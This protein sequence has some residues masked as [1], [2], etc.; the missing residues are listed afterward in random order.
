MTSSR[1]Q[2]HGCGDRTVSILAQLYSMMSWAEQRLEDQ[3]L[4][5]VQLHT[6]CVVSTH[7]VHGAV[8]MCPGPR[9]P[10]G[11]WDSLVAWSF[12]VQTER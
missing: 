2:K 11:V 1:I 8:G 4:L 12:N 7:T 9:A 10:P 3:A 6:Y 5:C